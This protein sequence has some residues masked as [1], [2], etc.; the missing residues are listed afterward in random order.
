MPLQTLI[1]CNSVI[2]ETKILAEIKSVMQGQRQGMENR[3]TVQNNKTITYKLK[4]TK[5]N[6]Q[7]GLH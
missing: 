7:L 5:I 3:H 4:Q 2:E 6:E 1:K